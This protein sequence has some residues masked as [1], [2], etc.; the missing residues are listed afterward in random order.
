MMSVH[1]VLFAWSNWPAVSG[2][3][4]FKGWLFEKTHICIVTVPLLYQGNW[5][6]P[7]SWLFCSYT[8]WDGHGCF[9][10]LPPLVP[11][12]LRD[13]SWRSLSLKLSHLR[14]LNS[15][16]SSSLRCSAISLST[17]RTDEEAWSMFVYR[18][19]GWW[20]WQWG[21][22]WVFILFAPLFDSEESAG[23]RSLWKEQCGDGHQCWRGEGGTS[24]LFLP[25]RVFQD[26]VH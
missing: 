5:S 15:W 21:C 7:T 22:F 12:C 24:P 2:M 20:E 4:T 1:L 11:R 6:C 8:R 10:S 3:L 16:L 13:F 18:V 17:L 19:V 25:H 26:W 14:G 9:P 23:L